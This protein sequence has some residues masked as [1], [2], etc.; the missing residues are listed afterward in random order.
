MSDELP[1][2]P[3]FEMGDVATELYDATAPLTWQDEALGFPWAT[4]LTS[5]GLVLESEMVLTG[6]DGQYEPWTALADPQRCPSDWL[7]V[8]AQWAGVR[9]R[10]AYS[11]TDLRAVLGPTAPGLWRGTRD[12]MI[13]A[14]RRFIG[15]TGSLFFEERAD[16]DPYSLRCFT[17]VYEGGDPAQ[18]QMALTAA[19]PAGIVLDYEQRVGQTYGMLLANDPTYTD[20]EAAFATYADV[21]SASPT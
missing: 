19:K 4:Y 2:T 9:N 13:A 12:A 1:P 7:N 6:G 20:V 3:P 11:E 15:P 5:L 14:A 18:I 21:V 16:G 10:S 8:L 17:Y